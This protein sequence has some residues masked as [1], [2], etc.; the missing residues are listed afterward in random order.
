MDVRV[1]QKECRVVVGTGSILQGWGLPLR[2]QGRDEG[3][4]WWML[5]PPV[6]GNKIKY[7]KVLGNR[8]IYEIGDRQNFNNFLSGLYYFFFLKMYH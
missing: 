4:I 6:L 1:D 7:N 3:I 2:Y 8:L 5:H